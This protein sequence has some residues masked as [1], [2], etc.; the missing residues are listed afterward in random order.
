MTL[1]ETVRESPGAAVV[2][3]ST[4]VAVMGVSLVS[5]ALPAIQRAWGISESEASLLISAFTLPGIFLTLP[6]GVVT[7][8]VGRKP[9]LLV[10]L[11]AFGVSG[12]A[13]VAVSGFAVILGLRAIQGAAASAITTL[14]VTLLGDLFSGE[15]RRVL[16]GANAAVLAIGAAGYPILGGLLAS[17]SWAVPF[18]CFL[19]ALVVAVPGF[20]FLEEPDREGGRDSRQDREGGRDSRQDREGGR[21]SREE[22]RDGDGGVA[23]DGADAGLRAFVT[24]PTSMRPFV[25]LYAA[26]FAVFVV[27]FGAQL[28]AVPFVLDD[29]YRLSS[30]G[31][32]LLLGIPA[33][34]MGLTA[35]QGDR[36]LRALSSYQSIA[37]GLASYGVGLVVVALADSIGTVVGGL[38]LFGV[39]QGLAEPIADT[40][41]TELAP[42]EVRGSVVSVRTTVLQLATTVG[43]PLFVGSAAVVGYHRTLL[44][45][46]VAVLVVGLSWFVYRTGRSRSPSGRVSD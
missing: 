35:T 5:P 26:V 37:L 15:R 30:R 6:I 7:D 9:V 31:I 22:G 45:G 43:P 29:T 33:V 46:G 42:E 10:S 17:I 16:I 32:G 21:D 39:G 11:V 14:T 19:L 41:L 23:R 44:G 27:L 2:F 1:V 8:R 12:G 40:A 25:T 34:T 38:L 13:I 36:I 18:A 28:T 4:L 3:A 20:V 24:G